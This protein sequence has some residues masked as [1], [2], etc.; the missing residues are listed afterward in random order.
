MQLNLLNKNLFPKIIDNNRDT[1]II[2]PLNSNISI[3]CFY[4]ILKF[5]KFFAPIELNFIPLFLQYFL[6]SHFL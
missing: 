1:K 6:I 3:I 4:N 2:E 5:N